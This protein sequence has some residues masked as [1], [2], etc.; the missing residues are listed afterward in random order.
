M[1]PV[2]ARPAIN[3][4]PEGVHRAVHGS[5][6]SRTQKRLIRRLPT[7]PIA[8]LAVII[9]VA[10]FNAGGHP[11]AQTQPNTASGPAD[12]LEVLQIR[13]DFY[14]IAGAGGNIAVQVGSDGVVLVDTG[15]AGT[16]EAVVAAVRKITPGPIGTSS[17]RALTRI[18]KMM[19]A[20]SR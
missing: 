6:M 8:T 14:M 3:C 13:P 16:A 20:T 5:V 17:S 10:A 15:L 9:P 19:A 4:R 7:V 12:D 11:L 18:T 1:R 2:A